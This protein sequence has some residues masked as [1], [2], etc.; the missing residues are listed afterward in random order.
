MVGGGF[1]QN[2]PRAAFR[3]HCSIDARFQRCLGRAFLFSADYN[4]GTRRDEAFGVT[5]GRSGRSR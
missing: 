5:L 2:P 3:R 1:P 4:R